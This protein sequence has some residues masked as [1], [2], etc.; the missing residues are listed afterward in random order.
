MMPA[1][2]RTGRSR[3]RP[4]REILNAIVYIMRDGIGWH[5]VTSDLP[6]RSTAFPWFC[7]FRGTCLFEKIAL[8]VD[9]GP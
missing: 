8:P 9:A 2:A 7:G 1:A 5:L 6:P 3:A 4:L